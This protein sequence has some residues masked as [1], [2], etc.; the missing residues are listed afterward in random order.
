MVR[1]VCGGEDG[2]GL[3]PGHK[4]HLGEVVPRHVALQFRQLSISGE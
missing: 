1:H 4:P 2:R 3:R